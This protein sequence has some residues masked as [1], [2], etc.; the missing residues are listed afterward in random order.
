MPSTILLT[1]IITNTTPISKM[2]IF[3]KELPSIT[4]N[5]LNKEITDKAAKILQ[6][7]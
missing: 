5:E 1:P 7:V 6:L 2:R 4:G 3:T